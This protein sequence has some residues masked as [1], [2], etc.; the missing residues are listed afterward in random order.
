MPQQNGTKKIRKRP[1]WDEYFINIAEVVATRSIDPDTQVGTVIVDENRRIV[2]TGYNSFPS[3]V[4]DSFWPTSREKVQLT[5]DI[6][7]SKYDC[8]CH[9]ELNAI[10][11]RT[12]PSLR[13]CT[14]YT[15][16]FPCSNCCK[17]IITAQITT[18]KYKIYRDENDFRI[19]KLLMEQAGISLEKVDS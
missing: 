2:A 17:A 13:K 5:E 6:I 4:D 12:V 11:A 10:A 1:N 3:G 8:I 7:A 19:S 16:L 14:L 9:S 18:V 15:T